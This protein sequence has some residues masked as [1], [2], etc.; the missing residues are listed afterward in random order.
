MTI[1]VRPQGDPRAMAATLRRALRN[2]DP[3]L[4]VLK[5]D[6]V[7]EQ[8]DDVLV[9][10][11]LVASLSAFFGGLAVLLA[12]VGLY[13]VISFTL[14]RRTSEMGIR[15]ALGATRGQVLWT[16][17]KESLVLVAAG[18]VAGVPAALA[19]TRLLASR[20]FGVGPADVRPVWRAL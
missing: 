16:V 19:L 4:T 9:Q 15:L 10:E 14:A 1:A 6:T 20:L 18:L 2:V 12:C 7:D 13:G 8:L 3:N 11:R 5:I 17:L